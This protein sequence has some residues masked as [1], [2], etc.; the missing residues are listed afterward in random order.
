MVKYTGRDLSQLSRPLP[1]PSQHSTSSPN[2]LLQRPVILDDPLRPSPKRHRYRRQLGPIMHPKLAHHI[3]PIQQRAARP[4]LPIAVRPLLNPRRAQVL[5]PEHRQHEAR[6]SR[7]MTREQASELRREEA[8]AD[9]QKRRA[10]VVRLADEIQVRLGGR[11][12]WEVRPDEDDVE[13]RTRLIR[14]FCIQTDTR[15]LARGIP[16]LRHPVELHVQRLRLQLVGD[17]QDVDELR[18]EGV[19]EVNRGD[20]ED[21]GFAHEDDAGVNFGAGLGEVERHNCEF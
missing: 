1:T 8:A 7:G 11:V 12:S 10:V 3:Q 15:R 9:G 6:S 14:I 2:Q 21:L 4:D 19:Q 5:L 16:L 20:V 18:R 17:G 13:R